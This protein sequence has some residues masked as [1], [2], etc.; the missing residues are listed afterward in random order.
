MNEPYGKRKYCRSQGE[1]AQL[2]NGVIP[3]KAETQNLN[4]QTPLRD[5]ICLDWTPAFAGLTE[6]VFTRLPGIDAGHRAWAMS[7]AVSPIVRPFPAML[8]T[9]GVTLRIARSG[10]KAW[11]CFDLTYAELAEG[12]AVA[13]VVVQLL[14]QAS[15]G[16]C[17][18]GLGIS[19]GASIG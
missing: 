14:N 1:C 19:S 3:A 4:E 8:P 11:G 10:Y 16:D 15:A 13:G 12:T 9:A 5:I 2:V 17:F 18:G 6:W 7:E